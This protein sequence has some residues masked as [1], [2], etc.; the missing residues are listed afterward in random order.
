MHCSQF[1]SRTNY[2]HLTEVERSRAHDSHHAA[3]SSSDSRRVN[4]LFLQVLEDS[5]EEEQD[6]V[7]PKDE[8]S[9]GGKKNLDTGTATLQSSLKHQLVSLC[10]PNQ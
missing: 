6:D 5:E 10:E 8:H 9:S 3:D 4:P 7:A 1:L 2:F